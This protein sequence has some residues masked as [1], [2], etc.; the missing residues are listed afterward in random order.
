MASIFPDEHSL[1]NY[2]CLKTQEDYTSYSLGSIIP[3][4]SKK[5]VLFSSVSGLPITASFYSG[6]QQFDE[7][8]AGFLKVGVLK[9]DSLIVLVVCQP[10]I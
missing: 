7:W 10:L 9:L 6:S 8:S 2:I 4:F 5:L 1:V 3:W